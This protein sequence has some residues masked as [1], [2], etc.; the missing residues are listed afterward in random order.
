MSVSH[1]PKKRPLSAANDNSSGENRII[2][3]F[4]ENLPVSIVEVE[5]FDRLISNLR[6]LA[7][8]DDEKLSG[9]G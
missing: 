4:S 6:S 2:I 9:Q 1:H 5:L 3:D 7:A 8:N